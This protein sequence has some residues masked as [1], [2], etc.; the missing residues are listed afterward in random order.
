M[1]AYGLILGLLTTDQLQGCASCN[2]R[3]GTTDRSSFMTQD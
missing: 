2:R 1:V 3:L